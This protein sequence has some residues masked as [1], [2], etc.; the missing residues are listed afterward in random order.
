MHVSELLRAAALLTVEASDQLTQHR[1]IPER[2]GMPELFSTL[3]AKVGAKAVGWGIRSVLA[4]KGLD[5]S[6]PQVAA[7]LASAEGDERV[8]AFVTAAQAKEVAEFLSD[9]AVHSLLAWTFV[10]RMAPAA[11][12]LLAESESFQEA[13]ISLATEW[14][15]EH[16]QTWCGVADQVWDE[17]V[18][19]Q[20][21]ICGYIEQSSAFP[22]DVKDD[23]LHRFAM[24]RFD[25]RLPREHIEHLI[26]L[27]KDGDR[28]RRLR[29]LISDCQ[30][31]AASA[32]GV[33]AFA[34]QGLE[35][36]TAP[37]SELYIDRSLTDA[38]SSELASAE[39]VLDFGRARPR[40]VVIGDP[41]VG[42]TTLT[43]WLRWRLS[44][45]NAEV[46]ILPVTI[47]ARSSLTSSRVSMIE[48]FRTAFEEAYVRTLGRTEEGD[49]FSVGA[50]ALIIDGID[51]ILDTTQR[52]SVVAQ[53]HALA[54]K[55]P[56]L[57]ILCTT[58]RRGFEVALFRSSTF[59]RYTLEEYN[60]EQVEEYARR[61]F[62]RFSEGLKADRFIGES[63]GLVDLRQNPLMLALLCTLYRQY[64]FIP[65]SRREVYTRCASLMFH[66][67]DPRRGINIP[68]LFK[69]EGESILREIAYVLWRQG[70]VT[71]SLD[72]RQLQRLVSD[73]LVGRGEERAEAD[74]SARELLEYCSGRAWILSRTG[75]PKAKRFAFTHRTFFEFFCAEAIVRR[76]NRANE[77]GTSWSASHDGDPLGV[78]KLTRQVLDA[79]RADSASVLPELLVQA[80]DDLMDGVSPVVL[81]ELVRAANS[82]PE[83]GREGDLLGLAVRLIASVGV[84]AA[85]A[86]RIFDGLLAQWKSRPTAVGIE[87]FTPLLDVA[88]GHRA[89]LIRRFSAEGP[90]GYQFLRR[91][92]RVV[93]IG[94]AGLFSDEWAQAADAAAQ[95]LPSILSES[96][97]LVDAH[98]L[99][100]AVDGGFTDVDRAVTFCGGEDL[101][102]LRV[103]KSE[104]PGLC[105]RTIGPASDIDARL[106]SWAYLT[107]AIIQAPIS[108]DLI[109]GAA[110]LMAVSEPVSQG[111][112]FPLDL[113]VALGLLLGSEAA[114]FLYKLVNRPELEAL[115]PIIEG[116]RYDLEKEGNQGPDQAAW[117]ASKAAAN[118]QLM[119]VYKARTGKIAPTWVRDFVGSREGVTSKLRW[120]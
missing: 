1:L 50:V 114:A 32:S 111:V 20:R 52:K 26:A 49:L 89:R 83:R 70:G 73:Y 105:W 18:S 43:A 44:T 98:A 60:E 11:D 30:R 82:I 62:D 79:Y 97:T 23:L 87:S 66:E 31:I 61:W 106:A 53:M 58:R 22:E 12:E 107:N 118:R 103:N 19:V 90:D 71:A 48:A 95:Q 14:C 94:E 47:I 56:A 42:K 115:I 120:R 104:S 99:N 63:R 91:Y 80:A 93:E 25:Q 85:S 88:S 34:V 101:L 76:M 41:G 39:R 6:P 84:N 4:S 3:G 92:A 116:L 109:H 119:R 86:D 113:S 28:Q 15:G 57:S 17:L 9:P 33:E 46:P 45:E 68:N 59:R 100:Y 64:D 8:D 75:D 65:R 96:T 117:K 69:S 36:S 51:E 81:V 40:A 108:T 74:R 72:E 2:T 16:G 21:S 7:V 102:L 29:T 5:W 77:L 10:A 112:T 38:V 24:E 27:A 55:Y 78:S 110:D 54:E 35:E 13:F 67:W 37:F